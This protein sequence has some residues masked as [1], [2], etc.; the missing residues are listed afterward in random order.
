MKFSNA[1]GEWEI[2]E[3]EEITLLKIPAVYM[4]RSTPI[5]E[6]TSKIVYEMEWALSRNGNYLRKN[7]K[8]LFV[9][10]ADDDV[11]FGGEKSS[12]KEFRAVLHLPKEATAS[13][14]TWTQAVDNY[15]IGAMRRCHS[16]PYQ[17]KAV[18]NYSLTLK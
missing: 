8:P 14:V 2:I 10:S 13:Y 7:S 6:D 17:V 9:V 12:I 18:S 15:P 1:N 4:Y 3:D 11:S 5:W 16:K